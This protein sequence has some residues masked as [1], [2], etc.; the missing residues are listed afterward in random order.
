MN[1]VPIEEET[2]ITI[3]TKALSMTTELDRAQLVYSQALATMLAK[4]TEENVQ[5]FVEA[6]KVL[7]ETQDA[8]RVGARLRLEY[9]AKTLV[10][11]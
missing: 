4:P 8:Y 10:H 1:T 11:R 5:A 9:R 3:K 7:F 6:N 2:K